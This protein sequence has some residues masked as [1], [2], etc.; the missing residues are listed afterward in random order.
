MGISR[1]L[2]GRQKKPGPSPQLPAP[3]KAP[4]A[5]PAARPAATVASPATAASP[6]TASSPAA[7]PATRAPARSPQISVSVDVSAQDLQRVLIARFPTAAGL[8]SARPAKDDDGVWVP[9]G[10]SVRVGGSTV[11]G[12][13]FYLG[14]ALSAAVKF[15]EEPSLVNTCLLIDFSQPDWEGSTLNYWPSYGAISPGERAAYVSWLA[16]ERDWAG[17]PIGF[18]FIYFYG[19]ERRVFVDKADGPGELPWIRSEVERLRRVY[20]SNHSFDSYAERLVWAIDCIAGPSTESD[21][22]EVKAQN[23]AIPDGMKVGLGRICASGRPLPSKWAFAWLLADPE[24]YLRTP[25]E[26]CRQEFAELFAVR[27]HQRYGDGLV[28]KPNKTPL[29]I[30]YRPATRSLREIKINVGDIPDVTA[31]KKPIA[32]LRDIAKECTESLDAYSRWL[33]RHPDDAGSL[34]AAAL[35]PV[36]LVGETASQEM[37]NLTRWV[38]SQLGGGDE[39]VVDGA[40]LAQRWP[41]GSGGKLPRAESASLCALLSKKGYGIEPD[42]RFGGPPLSGGATIL[43]RQSPLIAP[44]EHWNRAVATLDLALASVGAIDEASIPALA[45]QLSQSLELPPDQR[46]RAS[47]RLRWAAL[48]SPTLTSAKRAMATETQ[49]SRQQ[50]GQYLVELAARRGPIGPSQVSGLTKAYTALGLEPASMFTLIHERATAAASDPIEIR[51]AVPGKRGEAIP[52]PPAGENSVNLDPAVI[53]VTLAQSDQASALLGKIFTEGEPTPPPVLVPSAPGILGAPYLELLGQL[54]A[55]PTWTHADFSEAAAALGLM[56][57]GAL[58][59]LNEAALDLGGDPVL[60]GDGASG[61][62]A[63]LE[64][65]HDMVKELLG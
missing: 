3:A 37:A 15:G 57:N 41:G 61:G 28:I 25:A 51:P 56:P 19:L 50:V 39:C 33:G 8:K 22:P 4:S 18:V 30:V 60:E 40:E 47:A 31:L 59:V 17:M 53:A 9:P 35:L 21:P 65:N 2:T 5:K 34:A 45:E 46:L 26:R 64:V 16:S 38:E 24:T 42:V 23:W 13:A 36:E 49:R 58:E 12:G 43:F 32:A 11:G 63:V 20:G 62:D 55:R 7:T 44:P 27:Y 48:R 14:T 1:W 54:A 29:Q 6:P 10:Q 52:S